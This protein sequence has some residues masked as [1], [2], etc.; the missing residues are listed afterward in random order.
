VVDNN[1]KYRVYEFIGRIPLTVE[2][3]RYCRLSGIDPAAIYCR[4]YTF[5]NVTI[6]SVYSSIRHRDIVHDLAKLPG[7]SHSILPRAFELI[8]AGAV[9]IPDLA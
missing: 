2:S 6:G 7:N 5:I 9:L 8:P 3:D 4:K 1:V